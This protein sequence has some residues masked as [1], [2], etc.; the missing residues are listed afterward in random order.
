MRDVWSAYHEAVHEGPNKGFEKILNYA[1][2][3]ACSSTEI[4]AKTGML[5]DPNLNFT[6]IKISLINVNKT[7][8]KIFIPKRQ[9]YRMLASRNIPR[10][11]PTTS[12]PLSHLGILGA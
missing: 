11:L 10:I 6:L 12:L 9:A 7:M 4:M 5:F 1:S 8:L 2:V 3:T